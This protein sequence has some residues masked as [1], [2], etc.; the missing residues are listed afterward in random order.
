MT[1]QLSTTGDEM[2][3][4]NGRTIPTS[5]DGYPERFTPAFTVSGYWPRVGSCDV[6]GE[7]EAVAA[8]A[9]PSSETR[10]ISMRGHANDQR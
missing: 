3:I 7:Y 8:P 5:N 10:A 1:V 4:A 2:R 6:C 9:P